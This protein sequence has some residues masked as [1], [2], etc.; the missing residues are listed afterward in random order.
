VKLYSSLGSSLSLLTLIHFLVPRI[1][2][3]STSL[4]SSIFSHVTIEPNFTRNS[5]G[6]KPSFV[7]FIFTVSTF[8]V[9]IGS[10]TGSIATSTSL[11]G[12]LISS[13]TSGVSHPIIKTELKLNS[14][15][16]IFFSYYHLHLFYVY[17]KLMVFI[18][19]GV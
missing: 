19:F 1:I 10:L 8:S 6:T 2:G 14:I 7:T 15:L 13:T 9:T 4:S 11:T 17:T 3:P 18:L 12:S 16:L 5:S